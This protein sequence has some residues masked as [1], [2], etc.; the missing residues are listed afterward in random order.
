MNII[1]GLGNPGHGYR[2]SRH[3]VG[4]MVVAGLAREFGIA[5]RAG[6]GDFL[7]GRGRI[8]ARPVELVLPLTY[9]NRSGLAIDQAL[10]ALDR[11]PSDLLVVCDDVNLELGQLRLRR[12]GSDGGHNGLASIMECLGTQEF[13]RLRLGVGRPTEDVDM[14]DYVLEAFGEDELDAVEEMTQ[15]AGEAVA[16]LLREGIEEAMNVHNRPVSRGDPDGG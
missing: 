10:R 11:G 9:M 2:D 7:S 16:L 15:R 6:R 5:L 8:A 3:N 1:A 12:A 4:F 14:A 13:G